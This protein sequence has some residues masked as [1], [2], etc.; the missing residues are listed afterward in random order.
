M[1]RRITTICPEGWYYLFVLLFIIGGA[2]LREVNLLV[3]LAGMMI[4]PFLFNWRLVK[5]TLREVDFDRK[6]PPR[7]FAGNPLAVAITAHN[8]RN[9][10]PS[11][12]LVIEDA[13]RLE[14]VPAREN[15][16]RVRRVL[17]YVAAGQSAGTEYRLLLTRRGRYR[18]GPLRVSTR[19]PLGMVRSTMV[20]GR[21][22]Q[23]GRLSAPRATD[24]QLASGC[25]YAT[26]G[27]AAD[28]PTPG[29]SGRRLLRPA[30]M[31]DGR[32]SAMDSLA[33]IGQTWRTRRPPV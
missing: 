1:P 12:A 3:L 19:F 33:H 11:W 30:G 16:M 8:R 29:V 13:L 6:L 18:F 17:P 4:G 23:L 27:Q 32:Q 10:L 7:T 9:R 14:D 22:Q 24:P 20:V 2:V 31:A 26:R 21:P 28:S 15:R 5:L 25:R